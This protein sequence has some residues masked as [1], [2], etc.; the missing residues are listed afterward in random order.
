[1]QLRFAT[2]GAAEGWAEVVMAASPFLVS[3]EARVLHEMEHV[4][5]VLARYVVV[6]GGEVLGI[7]RLRDDG[8]GGGFRLML[9][10]RPDHR[11]RGVG[12]LLMDRMLA[13]ADGGPVVAV[14]NGDDHSTAV[15]KHWGFDLEREH[16]IFSVSPGRVEEAG[17]A[18]AGLDVVPLSEVSCEAVWECHQSAVGDEPSGLTRP[19]PLEEYLLSEWENPVHRA[20]LGRAVLDGGLV[21][22]Y[23]SM[24]VAGDRAWS[25]MTGTRPEHRGRGLAT[26]VKQRSLNALA[27]A[28]VTTAWTGNDAANAPMLAVNE[29]LGYR[30]SSSTWGAVLRARDVSP[31]G[32]APRPPGPA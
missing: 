2:V 30:R 31:R 20:D 6:A 1:M 16:A 4:P 14:V 12:R 19:M 22:S 26:L 25:S 29:R 11:D 27:A 18:P 15:A 7:A 21:L 32:S 28:G 13:V 5:G 24:L 3:S 8:Q 9:Q 10:V 17:T 23:T